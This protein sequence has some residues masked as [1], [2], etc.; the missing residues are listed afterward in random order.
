M[1]IVCFGVAAAVRTT[2]D[3][4]P[5][6]STPA[7]AAVW[8]NNVP[9]PEVWRRVHDPTSSAQVNDIGQVFNAPP[10]RAQVD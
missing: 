10:T 6:V 2:T 8:A 5:Q 3:T 7:V 9:R 1:L 4:F